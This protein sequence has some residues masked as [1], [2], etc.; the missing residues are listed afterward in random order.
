[1]IGYPLAVR[2]PKSAVRAELQQRRPFRSPA[3]EAAVALLRTAA[4]VRRSIARAV[5]PAGI[6]L[7]Q[8]NVLRILRG[9]GSA[10]LPTL[11]IRDRMIEEAPAI[12]RLVDK[13]ERSG[14][15]RRERSTP[16][17]RQVICYAT[18]KALT[19]LERL[20]AAADAADVA[21]TAMLSAR[22]RRELVRLL[23]A[24]RAGQRG[25]APG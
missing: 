10:G 21:A 24:I 5:E 7:A 12:T 16:D 17:R 3:Q 8:Y 4:V 1:M 2:P 25:E 13:L 19:L 20:D 11:A 18:P 6:S 9:A 23:D 22:E 15:V 14:L